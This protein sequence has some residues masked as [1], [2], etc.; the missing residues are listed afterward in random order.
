MYGPFVSLSLLVLCEKQNALGK[1]DRGLGDVRLLEADESLL[2]TLARREKSVESRRKMLNNGC[3]ILSIDENAIF[4]FK[5]PC[6]AGSLSHINNP[7]FVLGVH[8][9]LP[10]RQRATLSKEKTHSCH[11]GFSR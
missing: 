10:R 11:F 9:G 3:S 8:P 4:S 7:P 5:P 1:T 6:L 2:P